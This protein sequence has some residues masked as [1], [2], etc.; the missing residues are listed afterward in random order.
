VN[1]ALFY[2]LPEKIYKVLFVLNLMKILNLIVHEKMILGL[3]YPG[4]REKRV[5]KR[6]RDIK[7][8]KGLMLEKFSGRVFILKKFY[9]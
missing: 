8:I 7:K 2:S 1:D 3:N 5:L 4:K 6:I 9:I